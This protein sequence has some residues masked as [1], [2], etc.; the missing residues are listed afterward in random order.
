MT[1]SKRPRAVKISFPFL[2]YRALLFKNTYKLRNSQKFSR[3][4]LVDDYSPE[5]QENV[6]ELRAISAFA[7]SKGI[8]SR[9]R[10][11]T[12]IVDSKAYAHKEMKDLPYNLSI[13]NAKVFEVEDG[14][15]FQGKHAYL[16]NHFPCTI[17]YQDKVFNSSE[18]EYQYTLAI[19]NNE[20]DVAR[21]IYAEKDLKEIT[22]LS[23]LIKDSPEWKKKEVPT[24][25]CIIKRKFNQNPVL[26]AKL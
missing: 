6:K 23:K 12:I 18:Q 2:R 15:A 11:T 8:D 13:G 22:K 10:G 16:S 20:G 19:E 1:E 26:K 7:R 5:V 9:I 3:V 14:T 24:M 21:R 4:Y 25:A 17:K